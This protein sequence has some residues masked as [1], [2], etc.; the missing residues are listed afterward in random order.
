MSLRQYDMLRHTLGL[1]RKTV[2]YRNYYAAE[3]HDVDCNALVDA[4]LMVKGHTAPEHMGGL[5]YFNATSL[6]KAVA[7]K[8]FEKELT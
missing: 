7:L 4:G 8:P 6:G 1:N 2:P 3:I 5:T